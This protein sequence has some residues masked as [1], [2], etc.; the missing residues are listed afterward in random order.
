MIN[1]YNLYNLTYIIYDKIT[2]NNIKIALF[3]K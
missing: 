3:I 1:I 2:L